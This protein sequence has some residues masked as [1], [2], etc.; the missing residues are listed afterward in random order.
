MTVREAVVRRLAWAGAAAYGV[1]GLTHLGLGV[2]MVADALPST[3]PRTEGQAESLMFFIC[4]SVLGLL[5]CLIAVTLNRANS[6]VGFWLNLAL[7]VLVDVALLAVLIP[8]GYVDVAGGLA[9]PIVMVVAIALTTAAQIYARRH[10]T[11]VRAT[12]S[13]SPA[14]AG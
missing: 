6:L 12:S 9:G 11:A 3:G 13:A 7:T 2:A 5:C 8:P 10:R 1:W 14:V 4:A